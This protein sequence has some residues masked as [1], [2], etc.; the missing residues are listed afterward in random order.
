MLSAIVGGVRIEVLRGDVTRERVDGIVTAANRTLSGGNQ[1]GFGGG[2]DGAV[3]RAAGPEL[4]RAA[5]AIGG[6]EHGDAVATPPGRLP[7]K[8]V[9]HAV[10][11]IFGTHEGLEDQLLSS[12]YR[13]SLEV[14][15]AEGCESLAFPAISCGVYRF[16]LKRA[17][18]LA[19]EA[20]VDYLI[21]EEHSI[22]LVRYCLWEEVVYH[23]VAGA[24]W[25]LAESNPDVLLEAWT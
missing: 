22:E 19:M 12:A 7:V 11:P 15:T 9:I 23:T 14:A 5:Q 20:I 8:C 18:A 10:G 24:L 1:A 6:C 21:T 2:V 3:H 13:R 4:L 17:A 25:S 16:P